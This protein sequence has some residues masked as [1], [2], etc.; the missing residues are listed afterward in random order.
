MFGP[1]HNVAMLAIESQQ[2]MWLRTMKLAS[3]GPSGQREALLMV[4][5]KM[6]ASTQAAGKLMAGASAQ[7]IVSGYRRKVRA[8]A[9]RLSK[10]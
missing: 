7:S 1:W 3:G 8:N 4:A 6:A 10:G 5:E 9:R 2:V